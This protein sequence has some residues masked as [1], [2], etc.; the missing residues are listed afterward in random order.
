[1]LVEQP[2]LVRA[3]I[4]D[5]EA[6]ERP[7]AERHELD[8]QARGE[9]PVLPRRA[10]ALAVGQQR[11]ARVGP[12]AGRGGAQHAVQRAQHRALD[13]DHAG[14]VAELAE[15]GPPRGGHVR[16]A[17]RR[18]QVVLEDH[19]R[20][21][22]VAHDVQAGDPDPD[23][24]PREAPD[25]GLVVVGLLDDARGHDA[26]AQA[27]LLGVDVGDERVERADA[28]LEAGG[29]PGPLGRGDHPGDEVDRERLGVLVG[30]ERAVLGDEL[31][32]QAAHGGVQV[33]AREPREQPG[34]V[35]ARGA[36]GGEGL[37]V[38]VLGVVGLGARRQR[39]RGGR[40]HERVVCEHTLTLPRR[41]GAHKRHSG[42]SGGPPCRTRVGPVRRRGGRGAAP[43]RRP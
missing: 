19:E 22:A 21:V 26:L 23:P 30:A 9:A 12:A 16:E 36:G 42:Q 4:D 32:A 28:L 39:R 40:G 29:Q 8:A 14:G 18:A 17:R 6:V 43:T 2:V 33:G 15:D 11:D 25:R 24:R 13:G 10:V 5:V 1:V 34:V 37:V 41:R 35:L 20:P 38:E 27:A 7:A 3:A 31:A